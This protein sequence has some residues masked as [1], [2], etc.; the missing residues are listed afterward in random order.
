MD[1]TPITDGFQQMV[2]KTEEPVNIEIKRVEKIKTEH[3]VN[4][5][6]EVDSYGG[7]TIEVE[8]TVDTEFIFSSYH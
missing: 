2:V 1:T 4:I 3:P 7:E 8:D 5:L 6:A